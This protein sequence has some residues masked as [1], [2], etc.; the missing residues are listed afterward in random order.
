MNFVICITI[1]TEMIFT[2]FFFNLVRLFYE[3]NERDLSTSFFF[4]V[5]CG[6]TLKLHILHNF[7]NA[8]NFI[9]PNNRKR[10]NNYH[11]QITRICE[12]IFFKK[13]FWNLQLLYLQTDS[14]YS[15]N[16]LR[17]LI[18]CNFKIDFDKLI[19][20][21]IFCNNHRLTTK[22]SI[23]IFACMEQLFN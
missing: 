8:P 10:Q 3:K 1:S 21:N 14:T 19:R 5:L 15:V 4:W 20:G 7:W 23:V 16:S 11:W 22:T 2:L 13:P 9:C 6:Y 18:D 12:Q 17:K